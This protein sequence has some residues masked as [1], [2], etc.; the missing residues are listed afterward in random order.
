MS[1][2][3]RFK[4]IHETR[5]YFLEE[6]KQNKL[7]SRKHIKICAALNHIEHFFILASAITACVSISAF[8]SLFDSP[9][10]IT[11]FAIELKICA[12]ATIVKKY[13]SIMKKQKRNMIK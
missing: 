2:K 1:Q 4:N 9:V 11:S 7:M 10:G 6:I 13:K 3:Y 5:K 8:T 12:I